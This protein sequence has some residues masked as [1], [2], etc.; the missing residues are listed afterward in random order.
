MRCTLGESNVLRQ[1]R[2]SFSFHGNV[3]IS[4]SDANSTKHQCQQKMEIAQK[5][6][7]QQNNRDKD[8]WYEMVKDD[9][10]SGLKPNS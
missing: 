3:L 4:H 9:T 1:N 5:M 8:E 7:Q 10:S 6:E 2:R